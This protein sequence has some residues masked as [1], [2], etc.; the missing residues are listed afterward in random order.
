M[1]LPH[2][3]VGAGPAVVL[4]HAGIADRTMW[5]EQLGP[6]ADAGHRVVALDRPGFGEAAMPPE[7]APS[8]AFRELLP[9]V[10]G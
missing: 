10:V 9:E 2:D 6:I 4:L 8:S 7:D 5:R 3:D 1:L